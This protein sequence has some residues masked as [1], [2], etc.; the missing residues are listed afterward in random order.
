MPREGLPTKEKLITA[1]E[2]LFAREGIDGAHTRD[3]VT[4]AGQANDSAIHYHFG[5]R[6]GLLS[7]ILD[8]H[9]QEMEAERQL[10]VSRAGTRPRIATVVGAIVEPVADKLRTEDGR[11]FLR[12]IAQLAGVTRTGTAEAAPL[13]GTALA[14]QLAT[15]ETACRSRLPTAIADERIR[16]MITMLTA[17]LAD[18]AQRIESGR[19]LQLDH[20]AY[21]ANL[22]DM[23]AAALRAPS[24]AG[25]QGLRR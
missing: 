22:V 18:R 19:R 16:S 15:L 11:N 4:R 3:I 23:L 10:A 5:S 20:D 9:V 13:R 1:G 17:S 12:I 25:P 7:A 6:Q 2:H 24:T 8:K 21:V 14:A